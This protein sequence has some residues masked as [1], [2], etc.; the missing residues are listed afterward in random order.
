MSEEKKGFF[1]LLSPKSALVL[2][3]VGGLLTL[4]TIGFIILAIVTWGKAAPAKTPEVALQ[5]TQTPNN[6]TPSQTPTAQTP[7][8]VVTKSSGKPKVDLFVM[9][10]CPYGLQMEKAFLPAY[11]LLKNKADMTIKF[12]YYS[13]H[14]K[15]EIDEN[16]RQ[17]CIQKEQPSKYSAYLSCFFSAGQNDGTEAN[18][19][20]CLTKAGVN[21]SSLSSCVA[22]TDKQFGITAKYDDKASWLSGQFPLFPIDQAEN[23]KYGVQG[24]PTLVINGTQ[25]DV[26]RT[27]EEVKAAICAAFSNAPSECNQKLSTASFGAGFGLAVAGTNAGSNSPGC[28]TN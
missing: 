5:N 22:S 12:V 6:Q 11:D 21:K 10:Y 19:D 3:M 13:M 14:G 2:G 8:P 17:Y 27:P 4:G 16:T 26:G 20:S 25:A 1:E 18:Y 28:G 9:A 23:T 7:A 24:S 15:K